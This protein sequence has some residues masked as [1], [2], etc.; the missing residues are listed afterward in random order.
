MSAMTAAENNFPNPPSDEP[1]WLALAQ[2]V[3]NT[4]AAKNRIYQVTEKLDGVTV[5]V[6]KVSNQSPDLL[7]YFP[8]LK[9]TTG[10]IPIRICRS[11]GTGTRG[12]ARSTTSNGTPPAR[13]VFTV[14]RHAGFPARTY[15]VTGA[16]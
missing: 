11:G 10:S 4:Q 2:A 7:T 5:H 3:F 8:A 9:P 16:C 1:Q 13:N 6:Y 15:T 12:C 14:A